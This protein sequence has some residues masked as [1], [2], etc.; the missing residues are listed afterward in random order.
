MTTCE[1]PTCT[2]TEVNEYGMCKDHEPSY[3]KSSKFRHG[4]NFN[5]KYIQDRLK[6]MSKLAPKNVNQDITAKDVQDALI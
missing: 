4:K 5:I 6:E 1:Y 2:N 3:I